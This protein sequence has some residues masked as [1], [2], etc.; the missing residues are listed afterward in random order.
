MLRHFLYLNEASL[1]SYIGVVEGGISDQSTRRQGTKGVKGGEGGIAVSVV[2]A[3]VVGQREHTEDNERV[4]RDT[5]EI[6]F[7]RL[8]TAVE[9]DDADKWNY[10]HVFEINEAFERLATGNLIRIDC[11][12]EVPPTIA[13]MSQPDELGQMLDLME[14][15]APLAGLFGATMEGMPS[16]DQISA[17][18]TMSKFKTDLVV[19]GEVDDQSPRIAGKLDQKYVREMP[20]GEASI[21]GKVARRWSEGEHYPLMALPGA[22]LMSRA[23]RRQAASAPAVSGDENVIHG[24]ALTLDILAIFR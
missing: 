8:M 18:R 15:M 12:V 2:N 11:E 21:V 6:R 1:D 22:A 17:M 20:T 4:V 9:H 23:Q 10:E 19:V 7:D 14:N 24:P 13:I 16:S 3:K 5:P